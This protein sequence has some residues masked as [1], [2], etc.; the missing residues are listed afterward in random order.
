[1]LK[2]RP[3]IFAWAA[4]GNLISSMVRSGCLGCFRPADPLL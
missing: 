4:A 1:V 2:P 3:A